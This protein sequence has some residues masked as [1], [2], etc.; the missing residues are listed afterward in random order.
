MEARLYDF[1]DVVDLAQVRSQQLALI[2]CG[3]VGCNVILAALQMGWRHFTLVDFDR[4]SLHNCPRSGGL[5]HPKRDVGQSKARLLADYIRDWD[6]KNTAVAIEA[7][8]RDIGGGFFE[9]FDAVVCAV[10]SLE[11]VWHIGE[12]MAETGIPLYRGSTNG[13]N[14]SVE[15]VEN[16]AGEACLCCGKDPS[17]SR[18]SRIHSCGTRYV[19]N[20][21]QGRVPALQVSSAQCANRL[22][23][24]MTRRLTQQ[25]AQRPNI[26][27]YDDGRSLM[28]FD[29]TRHS[30]CVYHGTYR[31]YHTLPG[32]VFSVTLRQLMAML[33]ETT[34][35]QLTVW[36]A[37]DYVVEGKCRRCGT[38]YPVGKA[39]R[40]VPE[41]EMHCPHCP[42]AWG[43]PD[44]SFSICIF[45]Q[46]SPE[47]LLNQPLASLGFRVCD[48]I[49]A[50][51]AN[52]IP[53]VWRLTGDFNALIEGRLNKNG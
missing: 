44:E 48:G 28:A 47:I 11:A 8:V 51:G 24:E 12:M 32:D 6:E 22:V 10:D 21:K 36:S 31:G 29:L 37:D 26:R 30:S 7:D 46:N 35:R 2:G 45:S 4:V 39:L 17:Q 50:V 1:G 41:N 34:G 53:D 27:Y 20:I 9:Q 16:R 33:A 49:V 23:A 40:H 38:C 5:F 43:E 52:G 3:A 13:W 25:P 42:M 15:I 19:S 14:S 18:D